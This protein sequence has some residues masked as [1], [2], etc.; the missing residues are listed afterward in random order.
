M[1]ARADGALPPRVSAGAG[2]IAA[3]GVVAVVALAWHNG[4]YAGIAQS[5]LLRN[6]LIAVFAAAAWWVAGRYA[7]KPFGAA[8]L[9]VVA[10][11]AG[12]AL[13]VG[14]A[15]LLALLL[16]A[17]TA[18][19]VVPARWTDGAPVALILLAGLAI[20]AAA[21]GWLLPFPVHVRWLYLTLASALCLWRRAWIGRC[22]R[23]AC[24][25]WRALER[26]SP[27]WLLLA[28]AVAG[29]A[30]MGLWLPSLNYDDNAAHLI[31]PAQLRA[32][33]YYHLDVSTQAWAVAP[34]TNNVLNA[35]AALLAGG[36][37]RAA[38]DAL[39][40]LLGLNGAWRLAKA[41]GAHAP[42]ALAAVAM[43]AGL[44]MTAYFTTTLQVDGASAAVLLHFAALLVS[45]G[46]RLPPALPVGVVLGLLAGL[47]ASNAVFVLPAL[48]WLGW[49]ALRERRWRWI[50]AVVGVAV[51]L[52]GASYAY[53]TLVTGNPL[54]PLFNG[55][56]QSPLFP[57]ID[58]EDRRWMKAG[59]S[60]RSLWELTFDTA[61]FGEHDPGAF[62]IALLAL[63]PALL[64]EAVHRPRTRL[65]ALWFALAGLLM[66]V[67]IQY[68]R[69][70]F[71]A[72]APLVVVATVAFARQLRGGAGAALLS[73]LVAANLLLLPTTSWQF[74][75]DPWQRLLRQG[76]AGVAAIERDT[77]PQK[78]L[79]R[80]VLERT[81]D[82]C[83]LMGDP[84]APL[85]AIAGG[86]ALVLKPRYDL[87]MTKASVWANA[88]ASGER[89][90]RVLSASGVSHVMTGGEPNAPLLA[91]LA[92][93][94]FQPIDRLDAAQV[95]ASAD[96]GKRR[97]TGRVLAARDEARL[98]LHGWARR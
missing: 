27:G 42:A 91:A 13:Y 84:A 38:L 4:L 70:L 64:V 66:F 18:L 19:A 29:I 95:W 36:D 35:I 71:P 53:A 83:L 93:Q 98:H 9:C 59:V 67:Q 92:A 51:V 90:R 21:V 81:P 69:Y 68:A 39:W 94:G 97:C 77:L 55:W 78:V 75:G 11:V 15:T 62:G 33:G 46:Q 23:R 80:R 89:W 88:D 5:F 24:N 52:S 57:A 54:F 10:S 2:L 6:A 76:R 31:L 32:D 43:Y 61:R 45:C 60:W 16:L 14:P 58:L 48:A 22:L 65:V 96:P 86:R 73:L 82:A 50:A 41:L 85:G 87:R 26:R 30:A 72:V 1:S 44:P 37:A 56:F 8:T 12:F 28:T 40:L 3:A 47:K 7:G 34:W 63:L 25:R 49:L 74:K 20:L 17:G 79:L